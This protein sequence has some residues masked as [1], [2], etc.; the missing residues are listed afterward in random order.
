MDSIKNML[1]VTG[2]G[3]LFSC[4]GNDVKSDQKI[5]TQKEDTYDSQ[6]VDFVLPP[7]MSLAKSF[8]SAGLEYVQG[9]TNATENKKAYSLRAKQLLNMG[10]YCTDLAYC[11]LNGKTQ[12]AR[13]YMKVI[14]ELGNDVGLGSVFSDKEMLE[15]F[16]KSIGNQMERESFIYEL[17]EKSDDYLQKNELKHIAVVQFTGAWVEGMYLGA[18]KA[19]AHPEEKIG[20]VLVDQMNLLRNTLKGLEAYPDKDAFLNGVIADLKA[21]ESTY[22]N[23]DAVKKAGENPNLKAPVLSQEDLKMLAEKIEKVRMN[24]VSVK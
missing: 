22:S 5:E 11:S 4:S 14:Q 16:D 23:L 3:M 18:E 17:Q 13:E 21:V 7:F 20:S 8:Q 24:I 2:F 1:V 9:K 6:E 19:L 12:E 10:I 15:K